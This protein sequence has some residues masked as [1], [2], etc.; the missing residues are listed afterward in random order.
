MWDSLMHE[1]ESIGCD[2]SDWNQGAMLATFG[3]CL[4]PQQN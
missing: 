2:Y 4:G 1:L 3:G